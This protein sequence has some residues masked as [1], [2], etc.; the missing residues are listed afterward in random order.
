MNNSLELIL[1][2]CYLLFRFG[3][4]ASASITGTLRA[5]GDGFYFV[6]V[7]EVTAYHPLEAALH[8][9]DVLTGDWK[10]DVAIRL[11]VSAEWV[12]GFIAG[13]AQAG[14][15]SSDREF[16]CFVWYRANDLE[17]AD[18]W[19]VWYT[20]SRDAGLLEQSNEKAINKRLAPFA[21]GDDP[22]LVFETH[23][24]WAVGYVAGF[25]IL[26]FRGDGTITDAFRE[27]CRLKERLDDYPILDE[28]DYGEREY[29]ATLDNY[30]SEMWRERK[31]LPEG[32]EGEVFQW[33]SDNGHDPYIENRDDQGGFAPREK[34]IVA[35]TVSQ[36]RAICHEW[37]RVDAL[38]GVPLR[39]TNFPKPYDAAYRRGH[40]AGQ[41]EARKARN[42]VAD[43]ARR[44]GHEG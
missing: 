25:S 5:S 4:R 42:G 36:V 6:P 15:A 26:V 35:L 39:P 18:Q 17:D 11:G 16:T 33:F 14:E 10:A 3:L 28:Q 8:C 23:S 24:H 12:E 22:D 1:D 43:E 40:R 41:Q 2:G 20:S 9:Q 27:F 31:T 19:M 7:E 32:W 29:T 34:I 38:A 21:E 13:F 30:A 37:G 44:N